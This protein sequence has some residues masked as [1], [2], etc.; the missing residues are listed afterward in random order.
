MTRPLRDDHGNEQ[1]AY[2]ELARVRQRVTRLERR[3]ADGAAAGTLLFQLGM[4]APANVTSGMGYDVDENVTWDSAGWRGPAGM[5]EMTDSDTTLS[6]ASQSAEGWYHVHWDLLLVG[7]GV[8]TNDARLPTYVKAA[9]RGGD[10][11][12]GASAGN[13]TIIGRSASGAGETNVPCEAVGTNV[14]IYWY[15]HGDEIAYLGSGADF[16]LR[17]KSEGGVREWYYQAIMM[18]YLISNVPDSAYNVLL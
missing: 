4:L 18:G 13:F 11:F 17:I 14:P 10:T 6:P 8:G 9:L 2:R 3:P 15:L 12:L 5:F 1:A 16:Y 7:T